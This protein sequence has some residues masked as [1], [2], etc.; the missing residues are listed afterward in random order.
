MNRRDSSVITVFRVREF[1]FLWS[2]EVLSIFGDQLARVA[3]AVL[4]YGRTQSAVWATVVY[5]LTFLPALLGGV[6]LSWLA[7]RYRRRAVM[8]GVDV[9]RAGLVAAMAVPGVPLWALCGLLVVVVLLGSPFTAAQ[10]ALLPEVLPGELYDRGLA[11]RQMTSQAAQ[12]VGFAGGGV[13]VAAI[14]PGFALVAD[15]VTFLLSAALIRL[16][17]AN[18]PRPTVT[19]DAGGSV[20]GVITSIAADPRRR[21]LV[22]LAWLVGWYVVPEALAA[23][24]ADQLG[25]GPV[26]VGVLMA[27][28]PLGSVLGA[29]LF[30]RYVPAHRRARLVGVLAVCAGIPLVLCAFRPG[31]V[32]TFVLWSLSGA[33]STSY[34]LQTQ[35]GFVRAT[36]DADRGRAIG[37]AASGIVAA[38]GI[39]VFIG[40][41]MADLWDPAIAT[42]VAGATGALCSLA[43]AVAWRRADQPPAGVAPTGG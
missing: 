35:S 3:L 33:A 15:A 43:C 9:A 17:V 23:P 4:V 10:G 40:G 24:Y 34:L 5:A 37:V 30:V 32:L 11:V 18:R 2:A 41:L 38:Q 14:S 39:T 42:A 21:V 7:D 1:R 19:R 16:G 25:A 8:V 20:R 28:D 31:L 13:L 6:L 27:A 12:L 22:L 26:V 29:W 36:P